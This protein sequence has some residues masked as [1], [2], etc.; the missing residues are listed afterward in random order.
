[1]VVMVVVPTLEEV[2]QRR[3]A[4]ELEYKQDFDAKLPWV[5]LES[6]YLLWYL[7]FMTFVVR[8]GERQSQERQKSAS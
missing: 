2:N 7:Q 6:L 5:R 1:M 4:A 8:D 3:R